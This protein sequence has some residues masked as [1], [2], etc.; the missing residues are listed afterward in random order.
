MGISILELVLRLLREE[1]FSADLAYAG[2]QWPMITEPVAAV[3]IAKVDRAELTVTVAVDILSPAALG[4][5]CCEMAAL[6]ATEA[7]H[8]AGAE[9]I[10]NGCKYDGQ[11]QA[12]AVNIQATFTGVTGEEDCTMGPGFRVYVDEV[13]MPFTV[14]F[15][16]EQTARSQAYLETGMDP[17]ASTGSWAW[18]FRLEEQIPGGSSESEQ[19]EGTFQL[20][21]ERDG[22]SETYS[23]CSWT[24]VHREFTRQGLRRIRKGVSVVRQV[25]VS[26]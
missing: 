17:T 26:E 23:E 22:V 12:Y 1:N 2:R 21:L 7:L 25:S 5:T 4:G 3:H 19:P 20:R 6:R 18:E 15:Q 10:Q 13:P 8:G 24:S 14:S 9:C 16:S 11:A